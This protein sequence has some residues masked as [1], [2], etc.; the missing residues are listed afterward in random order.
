MAFNYIKLNHVL[1]VHSSADGMSWVY[2]L[3]AANNA[4]MNPQVWIFSKS[5]FNSLGYGP[6]TIFKR[7]T[8]QQGHAQKSLVKMIKMEPLEQLKDFGLERS[9][10]EER[11]GGTAAVYNVREANLS[12]RELTWNTA[13]GSLS[14][15]GQGYE[16][17]ILTQQKDELCFQECCP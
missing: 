9:T 13:G 14:S 12:K 17:L 2:L 8:D 10:G 1:L 16:K 15:V 11:K 3:S 5:L 6:G 4:A 7:N